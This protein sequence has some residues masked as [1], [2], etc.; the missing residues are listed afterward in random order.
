M[1]NRSVLK[2]RNIRLNSTVQVAIANVLD[3]LLSVGISIFPVH[4]VPCFF[5]FVLFVF[6]AL[7]SSLD[8]DT[9]DKDQ[10]LVSISSKN[11]QKKEKNRSSAVR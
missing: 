9:L 11:R 1:K 6:F 8:A 2:S 4:R 7:F 10:F 3:R 5:C